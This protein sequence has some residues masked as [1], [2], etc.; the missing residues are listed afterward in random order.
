MDGMLL[1][2]QNDLA[3]LTK[4]Q[5]ERLLNSA[6]SLIYSTMKTRPFD[7]YAMRLVCR[8]KTY[9]AYERSQL[10]SKDSRLI[11]LDYSHIDSR[12]PQLFKLLVAIQYTH[13]HYSIP[14]ITLIPPL[15]AILLVVI[16]SIQ[17]SSLCCR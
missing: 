13:H 4:M 15:I 5:L 1:D 7:H 6:L 14:I 3:I 17:L 9:C 12:G 16:I 2:E 11:R 10:Q 8:N